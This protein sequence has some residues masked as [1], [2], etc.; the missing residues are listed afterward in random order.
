VPIAE[1]A[2]DRRRDIRNTVSFESRN[3]IPRRADEVI[4]GS[5]SWQ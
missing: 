1:R 3:F 2:F 5:G 4:E